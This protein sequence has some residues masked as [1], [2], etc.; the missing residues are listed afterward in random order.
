[1]Q[2]LDKETEE[3]VQKGFPLTFSITMPGPRLV[4]SFFEP[5]GNL[6]IGL[7]RVKGI[8]VRFKGLP[9]S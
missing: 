5:Y 6:S 7:Y 2:D 8:P 1:V 4:E 9:E 3:M